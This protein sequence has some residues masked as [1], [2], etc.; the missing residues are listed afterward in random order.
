M[1][2]SVCS[3]PSEFISETHIK[4]ITTKNKFTI[5]LGISLGQVVTG[6]P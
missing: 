6:S 4:N 1:G 5:Q 2:F 3:L